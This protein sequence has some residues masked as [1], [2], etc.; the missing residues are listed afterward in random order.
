[1]LHRYKFEDFGV[2]KKKVRDK[3]VATDI[4]L[5]FFFMAFTLKK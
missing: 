5:S 2:T 1:M 3:Y 4:I